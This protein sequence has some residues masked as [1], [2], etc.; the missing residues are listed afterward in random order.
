MAKYSPVTFFFD[1]KTLPKAP[2]LMGLIISK[3]LMEGGAGRGWG[4][5]TEVRCG[6]MGT[7]RISEEVADDCLRW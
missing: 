5:L 2:L 1:K 3:S 6:E 7:L 4:W